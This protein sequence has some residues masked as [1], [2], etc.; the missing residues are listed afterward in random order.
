M[1][2]TTAAPRLALWK[3]ALVV[4]AFA[5]AAVLASAVRAGA[6]VI[7][8]APGSTTLA[9]AIT[10]ANTNADASNTII[11]ADG[12]YAPT[13]PL[14]TITKNLT[15]TGDHSVQEPT[16]GGGPR[17]DGTNQN[18]P[19]SDL[20]TV[21]SGVSLTLE[22]FL[23]TTA[24]NNTNAVIRDNGKSSTIALDQPAMDRHLVTLALMVD[25]KSGATALD[26]QVADKDK[27]ADQH[28]VKGSHETLA[29]A[30]GNI[31]AIKVERDRGSD[32]KRNT[33][34]WFAPQRGFLPVQIEQ[35]EKKNGETITMRLMT[36]K[37]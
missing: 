23:V 17:I 31:D 2:N 25:L 35:V 19:D 20:I 37:R 12:R 15:I 16:T 5:A 36:G 14:P 29:L 24:S 1:T 3:A 30:A 34:S 28:Y 8:P 4:A 6:A 11:L 18:P 22:G 32:S 7:A 13:G 9:A 33:T 26:Y 27:V 10:T 21:N